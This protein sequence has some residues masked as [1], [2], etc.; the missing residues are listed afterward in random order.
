MDE[1]KWAHMQDRLKDEKAE[2][3][4]SDMDVIEAM[5]NRGGSF[6]KALGKAARHA[7]QLNRRI[8]RKSFHVIWGK[9]SDM[10]KIKD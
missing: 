5:E 8:I 9:Y 4:P 2:A 1:D 10:A 7:D 3:T 6:V